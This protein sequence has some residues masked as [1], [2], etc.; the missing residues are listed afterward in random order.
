M[1]PLCVHHYL[2]LLTGMVYGHVFYFSLSP[3][4][5]SSLIIMSDT[6]PSCFSFSTIVSDILLVQLL[7]SLTSY[8]LSNLLGPC[9]FTFF[10][11]GRLLVLGHSNMPGLSIFFV[12]CFGSF[13]QDI[14][15]YIPLRGRIL[16]MTMQQRTHWARCSQL[17]ES[18]TR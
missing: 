4:L 6:T 16:N 15:T 14:C 18:W 1:N 12:F 13:T 9:F 3:H 17:V 8:L 5:I 7:L 11:V 2:A 10:C